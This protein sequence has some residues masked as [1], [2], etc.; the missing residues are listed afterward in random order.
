MAFDRY[1]TVNMNGSSGQYLHIVLK[2]YW[3]RLRLTSQIK[4]T[5]GM[6]MIVRN[7][8]ADGYYSQRIT[9]DY[10]LMNAERQNKDHKMTR[11][12][13]PKRQQRSCEP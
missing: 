2:I 4:R 5:P 12:Q 7:D 10:N 6:S 11:L 8:N 1:W 9:F 3:S 13:P